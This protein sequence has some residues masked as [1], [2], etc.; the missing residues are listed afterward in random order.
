CVKARRF[1]RRRVVLGV[2]PFADKSVSGSKDLTTTNPKIGFQ[3]LHFR[4]GFATLGGFGGDGLYLAYCPLL[5][6]R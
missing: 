3:K 6:K 1:W 5:T 4:S 2:L